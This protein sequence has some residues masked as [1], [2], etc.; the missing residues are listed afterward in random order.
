MTVDP[1]VLVNS[2]DADEWHESNGAA[3][4]VLQYECH[5][6]EWLVLLDHFADH[7]AGCSHGFRA[8]SFS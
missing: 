4:C 5:R 7:L 1:I 8:G 6:M 2:D 3:T